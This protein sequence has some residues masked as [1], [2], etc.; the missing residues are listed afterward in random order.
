[1]SSLRRTAP[2]ILPAIGRHTAT[3]IFCHGLGDTGHGWAD[4]IEQ[5][6]RKRRLDEIKFIL[7]NAPTIPITVNGGYPMPG[8]FDVKTLGIAA[9]S[10]QGR[11]GQEDAPGI[12]VTQEYIHGLIDS[13]ISA[14]IPSERI[15]LGGFSQGGA[16]GIFSGLTAKVKLGG[17]VALSSWL[18]LHQTFAEL[19]PKGDINKATPILMAHGDSDQVVVY[20]LAQES[21]K[22]LTSLGYDVNFK[23]Y[24]GMEHNA[25]LEELNEVEEFLVSRLPPKGKD[26]L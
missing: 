1:M 25:C 21:E 10:L 12:T 11:A 26:E 15:V 9:K 19:V 22:K 4:T 14:G 16:M 2:V 18:L 13:E 17:I 8:W 23:T 24:R 20:P 7:P 5:I 6:R 3:V